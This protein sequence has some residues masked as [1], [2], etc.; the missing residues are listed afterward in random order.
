MLH[1]RLA[2]Y[3]LDAGRAL[4]GAPHARAAATPGDV[5]S[6]LIL[7][8]A[9]EQ[10]VTASPEDAGDLA[11]LAFRTVCPDQPEWLE[12]GRR[13]LS[14]LRRAQRVGDAIT[15]ADALLARVDDPNLVGAV[16]SE[17][18]H[19]LWL[20]GRPG[21]MITRVEPVLAA[22]AV[23]PAVSAR[24]R[25][26][27]AL[28][29]TRLLVGES[30]ARE[31]GRALERARA[32]GDPD[33]LT[34]A[35]HAVGEAAS[36]ECRH[37][38]ALESF[39]ELRKLSGPHQLA[40]EVM[41][42]QFLDR[43]DH[44]Q[45]L[46]DKV[47]SDCG[48]SIPAILPALH[49]AQL[50]QDFNLGRSDDAEAGARALIELGQHLGSGKYALDAIVVRISLDLLRGDK[51]RAAAGVALADQFTDADESVRRPGLTVMR[52]WLAAS[53]GDLAAAVGLLRPVASGAL[54][55]CGYWPLWPCWMRQFFEIGVAGADPEF[56]E[57]VV[58]IAE[59]AASRN[60]GV[61]SFEGLATNIRARSKGDSA[62]LAESAW[63]LERSPRP[64]LRAYGADS[65]GRV[66]LAEGRRDEA[67]EQLDRAWD[68]YHGMD[69]R[70]YRADVQRVMR[71]AGV[72]R[73]EWSAVGTRPTTGQASLTDAERR[74]AM[75]IADGRSNRSA[76]A[77]RGVSV[78]TVSTH[79]RVVFAKLGVQ[80]RVQLANALR[81]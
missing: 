56:S 62:M 64:I 50:W 8:T 28:A 63:I 57:I 40:E 73:D 61:A 47:R 21:E 46:L 14:T 34:M 13:C 31:A 2:M 65:Y 75:L 3:E 81:K 26:A 43:Y 29:N 48:S 16:E 27:R 42:L 72:E 66:L 52:G 37:R 58:Q 55:S 7:I 74:V 60:P 35:L 5:T 19:A 70:V 32:S 69:A 23:D 49:C 80:S 33:A 78:N 68:E 9:A 11:M 1:C 53:R 79:L 22:G 12:V 71:E 20:G 54:G 4:M 24:L 77:E 44:A 17:A 39:R 18:A 45:L 15:V 25:A 10:L 6:A 38:D 41:T 76:A 59:L 36:N 67:L 51:Q 30:A